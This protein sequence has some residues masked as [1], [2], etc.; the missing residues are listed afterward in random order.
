M[1][2]EITDLNKWKIEREIGKRKSIDFS[3]MSPIGSTSYFLKDFISFDKEQDQ[4]KLK[5]NSKCI[6]ELFT[7]GILLHSNYS[8]S[9]LLIPI[10]YSDIT[11][12][13]L[14]K[15]DELVN[16]RKFSLMWILLKLGVPLTISRYFW[17]GRT[18]SYSIGDT[19]LIISTTFFKMKMI[20]NGFTFESQEDFFRRLP[21]ENIQIIK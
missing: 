1:V 2:L 20:T 14:I 18:I 8:T 21:I 17:G 16:P 11:D 4:R 9:Q 10:K 19:E 6:F 15:G 13:K 5:L 3:K 12:L 7:D